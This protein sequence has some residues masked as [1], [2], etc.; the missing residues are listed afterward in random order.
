V[1]SGQ[2]A[3]LAPSGDAPPGEAPWIRIALVFAAL[4]IGSELAYYGWILD[5]QVFQLYLGALAR[6]SGVLLDLLDQ[7][8]SVSGAQ[9]SNSH[10]AVQVA[11]G[12]VAIQICALLS[13]AVIAFPAPLSRRLRGVLLGVLWLQF[14]NFLRIASL[15]LIGAYYGGG[16]QA[17]HKVVW[18]GVLIVVTIATW[19]FWV[20]REAR[21]E[22][23][24]PRTAA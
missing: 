6:V 19:I 1:R 5:S 15:F 7:D 10:F 8:V 18:P 23:G 2:A 13:A 16:F 24:E 14:L 11:D 17:A 21:D 22:L 4:A 20:R 12:C 9:I 3:P